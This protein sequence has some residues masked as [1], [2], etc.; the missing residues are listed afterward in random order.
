VLSVNSTRVIRI[1]WVI[2]LQSL[3]R[4]N[5]CCCH[6][7]ILRKLIVFWSS[8]ECV[9]GQGGGWLRKEEEQQQ[10]QTSALGQG[11]WKFKCKGRI[12]SANQWTR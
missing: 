11:Q 8:K 5:C 1:R 6:W 4:R 3:S 7:R 10:Q 9:K 2:A 12:I